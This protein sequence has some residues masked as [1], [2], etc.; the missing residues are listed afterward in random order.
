[1][2][3]KHVMDLTTGS[4]TKKLLTFVY[5]LLIANL[6][7]HLYQATDNAVVGRFVGKEALAAVG[8]TSSATT[9]ILNMIVGLAVGASIVN[10]NLLGAKKHVE[11][12]RSMHTS[13]VLAFFGGIVMAIVGN[14]VARPML[15]FMS[16]PEDIVDD[17]LVYMRIIL[18][19]APGTMLYNFGSGILRTH[20]DSKRPM[21]IMG[22]SGLVNVILNLVFVLYFG[23]TVDGVAY[24]TII[25]KYLSAICVLLI[26]F[27]PKGEFKLTRKELKF[28]LKECMNIIKVGVPCGIN[29]IVFS[30]SNVIVQGAVNSFGSVI[31]A[32]SVASNNITAFLYQILLAFYSAC[33]SFSGQCY[34]ALKPKRI[35]KV[36]FTSLGLCCSFMMLVSLMLTLWPAPFLSIFNADPDVIVAGTVKLIIMSWSY[37]IY[38]AS[39][40]ILG[41]LRG[42]R[43]TS[44]STGLNIFCICGI[45]LLWIWY[46]CPLDPLNYGLL[47]LCY[48]V[49]YIFSL[50]GLVIYYV[51]AKKELEKKAAAAAGGA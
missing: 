25:S 24:A 10:G 28:N 32:G 47:Y 48:P 39:E 44:I 12:R 1:M 18:C 30:F 37:V 33:V 43:K 4:V 31:I 49:S 38:A 45:R 2:R 29:G 42:M 17:S 51:I 9:L 11:L 26:L 34:G 14:L 50:T 20:G 15:L 6:L 27:D 19:G 35:T 21:F 5:P 7:Q 16:C 23:M 13:L 36:V 22:I 3:K 8:S 46:I 40:I 41:C